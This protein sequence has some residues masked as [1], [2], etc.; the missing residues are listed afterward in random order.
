M[1]K[2]DTV[3]W[4]LVQCVLMQEEIQKELSYEAE[5]RSWLMLGCTLKMCA[6]SKALQIQSNK[7][8][9]WLLEAF[10]GNPG[11]FVLLSDMNCRINI[12][13]VHNVRISC[14][15]SMLRIL[16]N[17]TAIGISWLHRVSD[18][19]I[20]PQCKNYWAKYS[21]GVVKLM[22]IFM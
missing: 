8:K 7:S 21:R 6:L 11:I 14:A 22:V 9:D 2:F 19:M 4:I 17:A 16:Y 20:M 15:S 10:C 18:Y 3:Y 5:R 1:H 13:D 12:E